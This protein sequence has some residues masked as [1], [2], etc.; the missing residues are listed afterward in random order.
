MTELETLEIEIKVEDKK[1]HEG[2]TFK[3][4]KALQNNGKWID[5]KFR[6]EVTPPKENCFIIVKK[7]DMNVDRN[8]KFPVAWVKELQGTRSLAEVHNADPYLDEMFG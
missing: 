5:L 8:R 2:K 1:T 3:A 6:K 7:T 4:Y